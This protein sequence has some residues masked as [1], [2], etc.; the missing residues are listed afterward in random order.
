MVEHSRDIGFY[1]QIIVVCYEWLNNAPNI[2]I[3]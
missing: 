3:G 1:K 2:I